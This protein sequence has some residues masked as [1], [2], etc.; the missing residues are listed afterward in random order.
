[1]RHDQ[2]AAVAAVT[3]ADDA[4]SALLPIDLGLFEDA[5]TCRVLVARLHGVFGGTTGSGKS[6]G[7]NVLT[8]NLVACRD[9]VIWGIDLKR[10]MELGPWASCINRLAPLPSKQ[11]PCS[12]TQSPCCKHVRHCSPQ[13]ASA[14]G[15]YHRTC[16]R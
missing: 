2:D 5:S 8:G 12:A 11:L 9:V 13:R 6:G 14:A 16:P 15:R 1:V 3:V 7:L 4:R 10:E